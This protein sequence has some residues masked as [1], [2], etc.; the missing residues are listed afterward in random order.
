MNI[1]ISNNTQTPFYQQIKTQ[2]INQ[3]MNNELLEGELMPSIRALSHDIK[4][5]V[6]TIKKAYDELEQEGYIEIVHG[7]G[8][9]VSPK[10]IELIKEQANK[11]IEK[12][13]SNVVEIASKYNI[14]KEEILDIFEYIYRNNGDEYNENSY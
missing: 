1:I 6:M 8:T 2:I 12:H 10:N 11:E 5:S 9:Y 13:I 4:L 3:I 7:K 14:K